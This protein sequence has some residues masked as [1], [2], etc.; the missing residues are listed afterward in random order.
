MNLDRETPAI[1]YEEIESEFIKNEI[2]KRDFADEADR[3]YVN[4]LTMIE[5]FV[6]NGIWGFG[7]GRVNH[8]LQRS[9]S[10]EYDTIQKELTPAQ[11]EQ[12]KQKQQEREQERERKR[13]QRERRQQEKLETAREGWNTIAGDT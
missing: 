8:L 2:E 3:Y 1:P 4:R 5:D 13:G 7:A 12:R 6:R 9:L 10:E 11:Y